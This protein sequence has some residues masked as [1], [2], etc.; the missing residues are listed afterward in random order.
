MKV[1]RA[2][3]S[4]SWLKR[5]RASK[6]EASSKLA[7]VAWPEGLAQQRE[8]AARLAEIADWTSGA[9][10]LERPGMPRSSVLAELCAFRQAHGYPTTPSDIQLGTA[11]G[12]LLD[13]DERQ[14]KDSL[15]QLMGFMMAG[16]LE[17]TVA[18]K[19]GRLVAV[20]GCGVIDFHVTDKAI[21]GRVRALV[22]EM[23]LAES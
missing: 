11:P 7:C 18:N 12:H 3:E 10:V 9:V 17:G 19:S 4:G 14:N 22:S 20:F 2:D 5:H 8:L 21:A 6:A 23:G 1:L 13:D 15:R 16:Y